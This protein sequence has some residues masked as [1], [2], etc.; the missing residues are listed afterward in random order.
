MEK[1]FCHFYY[2]LFQM[3]RLSFVPIFF[4]VGWLLIFSRFEFLYVEDVLYCI[5]RLHNRTHTNTHT[6]PT[7]VT[8]FLEGFMNVLFEYE[9]SM[10]W[11][12]TNI[13]GLLVK[14]K[15]PHHLTMFRC[16]FPISGIPKTKHV[17]RKI[18]FFSISNLYQK[19]YSMR[20]E[21]QV[22]VIL[23]KVH[24][25]RPHLPS[26]LEL[27]T[28]VLGMCVRFLYSHW[29]LKRLYHKL[30]HFIVRNVSQMEMFSLFFHVL[31]LP[32]CM[33]VVGVHCT[34]AV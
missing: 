30:S 13:D 31:L 27:C 1:M 11:S 25:C 7:M 19:F 28:T 15:T 26:L 17:H 29:S 12:A 2:L 34:Q 23:F 3:F 21:C 14:T 22:A 6:Y 9:S 32:A 5:C 16:P 24:T 18:V 10:I 4:S 8:H 20:M 33:S